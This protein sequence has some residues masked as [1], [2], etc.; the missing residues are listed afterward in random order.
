MG[1]TGSLLQR[2]PV[3][4]AAG[5]VAFGAVSCTTA[6]ARLPAGPAVPTAPVTAGHEIPAGARIF[7][8]DPERTRLLFLVHRAGALGR[9]GHNHVVSSADETGQ[10]WLSKDGNTSGLELHL[11]VARFVVDDP[12]ARAE[13]GA[14]FAA[15]VPDDARAGTFDNM[16]GEHVLDAARYP[17]VIV[18]Y[19]G[20]T[21]GRETAPVRV[22]ITIKGQEHAVDVPM[23]VVA[24]D[25]EITAS[26]ETKLSQ[27]E[28]GLEPFSI[29]GGAIAVADEII[30]RF[31][32]VAK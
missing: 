2:L 25:K 13:S 28:L 10:A 29:M 5:A 11:P 16:T 21:P 17:E 32:L 31:E 23:V 15:A 7:A 22:A 19:N 26:G 8:V 18:R 12:G 6:P 27:T 20:S 30:V 14:D 4:A 9:L 3:V 24:G 1:S